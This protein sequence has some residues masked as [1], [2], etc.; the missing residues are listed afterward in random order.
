[1]PFGNL[2]T[3]HNDV[4]SRR[5]ARLQRAGGD[6]SAPDC[7]QGGAPTTWCLTCWN[8]CCGRSCTMSPGCARPE[9]LQSADLHAPLR[10]ESQF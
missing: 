10:C 1:M 7:A 3:A 9:R 4:A 6:G 8:E 5:W 2:R